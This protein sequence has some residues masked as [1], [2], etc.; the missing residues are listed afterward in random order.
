MRKEL[1]HGLA[2]GFPDASSASISAIA[3]D[4][5]IAVA[6]KWPLDWVDGSSFARYLAR[7][8]EPGIDL[9]GGLAEVWVADLYLACAVVAG[10]TRAHEAFDKIVRTELPP[11]IRTVDPSPD[12]IDEVTEGR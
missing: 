11:A 4:I 2:L 1:E 5:V 9:T 8:L 10:V 7:R 3:N 12:T 6:A